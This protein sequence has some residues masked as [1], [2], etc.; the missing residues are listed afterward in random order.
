MA[1]SATVAKPATK[2][3]G[4]VLEQVQAPATPES[5]TPAPKAEKAK[6]SAAWRTSLKAAGITVTPESRITFNEAAY[7]AKPKRNKSALRIAFYVRGEKGMSVAEHTARY[8]AEKLP[9]SFANL[10]RNWD[11]A[12][13]FISVK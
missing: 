5:T 9:K 10:D 1:R 3:T 6:R 12:H 4:K 2:T 7:N 11:Y 13:G 8:E